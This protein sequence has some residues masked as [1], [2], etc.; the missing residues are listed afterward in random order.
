MPLRSVVLLFA[1]GL[2]SLVAEPVGA[3]DLGH[4]LPGLLGLDA[5][6]IPEPG[7][8]LADRVVFYQADEIRDRQGE[9]IPVA[10]VQLQVLGNGSG[11]SY[12]FAPSQGDLVLT[13]TASV[14]VARLRFNLLDRP[15]ASVDRFGLTDFYLQP[16]RVGWRKD[17]LGLVGSYAVY[18]PSG[19]SILAGGRG[20]SAGQVT[21]QCSAGGTIFTDEDRTAFATALASYALNRRKRG[22]D[23]TRGDTVQV[24]GGA[25]VRRFNGVLEAGLAGYGLWQVRPDRGTDLPPRLSGARDRVYG[26]GP[27]LAL[28][29]TAIRSQIRVRY[30]WDFGVRSRPQGNIFVVGVTLIARR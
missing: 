6:A 26:L 8:Y 1:I 19:I 28:M 9:V 3:Q 2:A 14:P 11:I 23:I 30:E 18:V 24:E 10:N 29:V 21:H 27:E 4:K 13:L 25:G 12:T 20:L 22:I 7:L 5:A 15:E 16:A 17:R